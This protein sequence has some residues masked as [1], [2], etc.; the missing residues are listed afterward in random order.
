MNKKAVIIVL[1][2]LL[3]AAFG[4]GT[5]Y[6]MLIHRSLPLVNT[7]VV[8]NIEL[9]LTESTGSDYMLVPGTVINKDP[10][11]TV[12]GGSEACWLFFRLECDSE[13]EALISYSVVSGWTPLD[14]ANGVYYRIVTASEL[15]KDYQLLVGNEITV[16]PSVTEEMLASVVGTP[17]MT[18]Y[19]YAIQFEG[20][21]TPEQAWA[22]V[23]ARGAEG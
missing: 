20:I 7:F 4:I 16:S 10:R 1:A 6:A 11:I 8:G 17:E 21:S 2:V 9:A 22:G 3:I 15:D 12:K 23:S 18:F 13:L 5:T 19:A 14:G